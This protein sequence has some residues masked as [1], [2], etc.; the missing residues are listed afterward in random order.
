MPGG[1]LNASQHAIQLNYIGAKELHFDSDRL[2]STIAFEELEDVK[3]ETSRT[4]YNRESK[5][6]TIFA[7]ATTQ[8]KKGDLHLRV[9]LVAEF[10][11]DESRFPAEKVEEWASKAG[12]LV[13]FPYVREN[14]YSMCIR[15]GLPMV[16]LPLLDIPTYKVVAPAVS[17]EPVATKA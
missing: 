10:R 16:F 15:T 2:P 9:E 6:I 12:F 11:V 1:N 3:F 4:P 17:E 7:R 13:V 14:I 5:T 8:T